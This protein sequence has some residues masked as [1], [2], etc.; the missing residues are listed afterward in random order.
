MSKEIINYIRKVEFDIYKKMRKIFFST[1]THISPE[2]NAKVRYREIFRKRLPLENPKTFEEK[3]LWLKLNN[4][5]HNPLVVKC[6]DKYEVRDYVRSCG[7]GQILND[8]LWVYEK[9]DDIKWNELPERFVL[10]WNFGS[11]MNVVCADKARL[12]K[13]KIIKKMRKWG[14]TRYWLSYAEMQYKNIKKKILC[15]AYLT[16]NVH[17]V[18]PDYKVYC[19][20]GKPMAVLVILGRG[21]QVSAQFYDTKWNKLQNIGK[22]TPIKEEL[23]KPRCIKE[24][25]EAAEKLSKE[26]PFVRCDFYVVNEKLY[27]GEL[28]FT[29]AGGFYPWQTTVNGKNIADYIVLESYKR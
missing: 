23:P 9:V 4:Y 10:K 28:T 5:N 19:V 21:G 20:N 29:P 26:F 27:F 14:K 3:M 18:I 22:Y 16:D 24:M 11:G 12:D 25:L 17:D 1:L 13:T 15:E 8:L 7:C 2:L 6:A